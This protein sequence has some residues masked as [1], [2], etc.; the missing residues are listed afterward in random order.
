[1]DNYVTGA[2]V[3]RL[4]EKGKMTQSAVTDLFMLIAT[5]TG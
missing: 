4:R 5:D 1:M 3:K 2:T